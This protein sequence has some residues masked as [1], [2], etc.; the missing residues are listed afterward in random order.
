MLE[1]GTMVI[2][3]PEEQDLRDLVRVNNNRLNYNLLTNLNAHHLTEILQDL[4]ISSS[5]L[6]E[7]QARDEIPSAKSALNICSINIEGLPAKFVQLKNFLSAIEG[8]GKCF[9]VILL[10]ETWFNDLSRFQIDGYELF[11]NPREGFRGG[12]AIYIKDTFVSKHIMKD[13]FINNSM[14]LTIIKTE[15][16]EN[17]KH[18][19]VSCYHPPTNPPLSPADHD[20]S[21]ID[22]FSAVLDKLNREHDCPILVG[23]DFNINMLDL[24]DSEAFSS[25]MVW[26]GFIPYITRATRVARGGDTFS[27]ID[28]LFINQNFDKVKQSSIIVN[29]LSDHFIPTISINL[30]KKRINGPSFKEVRDMNP[31][32]KERFKEALGNLAWLDVI[33]EDCPERACSKFLETFLSLFELYFPSRRVKFNKNIH[34][35]N[36]FM[37][38]GL[39]VSRKRKQKLD[40]A[41]RH[42]RNPNDEIFYRRYRNLYFKLIR[43]AKKMTYNHK[44]F[45]AGKDTRQIWKILKE[46]INLK[47]KK[48]DIGPIRVNDILITKDN[49][50]ADIFNDLFA[51]VGLNTANDIPPS[52]TSFEEFLPPQSVN[53]IFLAPI[54]PEEMRGYI[55]SLKS[56]QSRDING[57]STKFLQYLDDEISIP[58]CHIFNLMIEH[59][60]FPNS[61]KIS[62][63]VPI[64]KGGDHLDSNNYRGVS[65]INNISKIMEK[66]LATKF[67]EFLTQNNFFY[68]NQFGFRP[69]M[70]TSMALTKVTN[71]LTQAMNGGKH[72]LAIYLD[73]SKAFDSVN[74]D[75]LYAKLHNCGI[76]GPA[77]ALV[78]SYFCNRRQRA[79]VN[80]TLSDDFANIPIG[81]LQG[82]IL[83]VLFFLIFVNDLQNSC[84]FMKNIMFA[85]DNTGLLASD[86]MD[87]LILL[88]N[89]ELDNLFKWY[90]ANKLSIHP[91]KSRAMIF[92]PP[93]R[94]PPTATSLGYPYIPLY[95]DYNRKG[96]GAPP[97]SLENIK[98]IRL[99]PNPDESSF[100]LLGVLIDCQLNLKDHA[101][102]IK[103]KVSSS[104]FAIKQMKNV[105]DKEHLLML[106]NAY[107]KS[108]LEYCCSLFTCFNKSTLNPIHTLLKKAVRIIDNAGPRDHT[109]QIFK[110]FEILPVPDMINFNIAKFMHKYFYDLLPTTFNETWQK[111]ID[112]SGI[113]TRR[114]DDIR[115]VRFELRYFIKQ[116]LFTFPDIWNSLPPGLKQIQDEHVFA[117]R[118]KTHFLSEPTIKL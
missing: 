21:F 89:S 84:Q 48:S 99:I 7:N 24:N 9:D 118:A 104:L 80:G 58:L 61:L 18:I 111:N 109:E 60:V 71:F 23:G 35:R 94:P 75:I 76:R 117:R 4:D 88:A 65:L 11:S 54:A 114:A 22:N 25:M 44:V 59:G 73:V 90:T 10:Q 113:N 81:V 102:H 108:H 83:G 41:Q 8:G 56:K 39:L 19:F 72:A 62:R 5:Y 55:N 3:I 112:I 106:A 30:S 69:K 6:T 16:P 93:S 1:L 32:N 12:T 36:D 103:K 38:R 33:S 37:T 70:S 14:E 78:K 95:I 2:N 66:I 97:P 96:D 79:T 92:H 98:L 45:A 49:E 105:L 42:S 51:K 74:R 77:L 101:N 50:K 91:G 20:N 29:G 13:A 47:S 86:S 53:S 57:L 34:P 67:Q 40:Y 82:S 31:Q 26:N 87:E 115:P 116:P 64:F 28:N 110:K 68:E 100:K 46:S 15:I 17:G 63:V 85:D 43:C 27:L 107:I 52:D